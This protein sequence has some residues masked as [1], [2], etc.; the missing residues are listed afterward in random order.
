[1]DAHVVQVHTVGQ[2]LQMASWDL[3]NTL[4]SRSGG[5]GAAP[6]AGADEAIRRTA[7]TAYV[8]LGK[9]V[10]KNLINCYLRSTRGATS[11]TSQ[12]VGLHKSLFLRDRMEEQMTNALTSLQNET[13][14]SMELSNKVIDALA[15][16]Q[17]STN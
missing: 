4:R 1:M 17:V 2:L 12:T 11:T 7:R 16:W 15:K 6:C 5:D 9:Y 14:D 10:R 8:L 3:R 13:D